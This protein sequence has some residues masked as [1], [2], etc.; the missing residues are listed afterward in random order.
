MSKVLVITGGSS[1]I[2]RAT[3]TLFAAKGWQV[4]D[5]S[6]HAA[7][8]KP[9]IK[10]IYCD[11]SLEESVKEAVRQVYQF[12]EQIDVLIANA[13][14]GISGPI[15]TTSF[16]DAKRQMDVNFYG[17][18]NIVK[19]VLPKM[20]AKNAGRIIFT[21]SVAGILPVPYQAFY[22]ASKAAINA[23]SLALQNEVREYNIKVSALLPG[24]VS[25]AFTASRIKTENTVYKNADKAVSAME[26]DEQNGMKPEKMAKMMWKIAHK[27]NPAPLYIGGFIYQIFCLLDRLLPKRIVNR[28]EGLLY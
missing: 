9:N 28:I 26:K 13:G 11:V 8:E 2:G 6:R 24:D 17:A 19:A 25:T 12:T 4:F 16:A 1:G 7:E 14:F 15:E 5:L 21:S 3:A 10:H 22:S 27:K 23:F 20:R 18:F